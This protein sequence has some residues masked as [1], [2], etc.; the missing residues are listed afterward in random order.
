M[1][2]LPRE[3]LAKAIHPRLRPV[4]AMP[5]MRTVLIIAWV[6][7]AAALWLQT[8]CLLHEP[9]SESDP[10]GAVPRASML[11]GFPVDESLAIGATGHGMPPSAL[12]ESGMPQWQVATGDV[13]KR[14]VL[15][16]SASRVRPVQLPMCESPPGFNWV[17][18]Y[19]PDLE[20]CTV[21]SR[22]RL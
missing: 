16:A 18:S 5:Q 8:T 14:L 19:L 7:L 10:F 12:F 9:N 3:R 15:V 11:A 13:W 6:W 20:F 2:P 22:F 21:L 17:S 4:M 1:M